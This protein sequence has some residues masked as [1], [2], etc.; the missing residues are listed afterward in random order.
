MCRGREGRLTH[1]RLKS[2]EYAENGPTLARGQNLLTNQYS[3]MMSKLQTYVWR[4]RE[5]VDDG[6][7]VGRVGAD[8]GS[9]ED[10]ERLLSLE[11]GSKGHEVGEL[12]GG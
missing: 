8:V 1:P 9:K 2:K 10:D 3:I 12:G 11:G 6:L 7:V 4:T 5:K